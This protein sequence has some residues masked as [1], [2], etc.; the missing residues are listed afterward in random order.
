MIKSWIKILLLY[1]S[2]RAFLDRAISIA[3][4]QG[5][6]QAIIYLRRIYR[7]YKIPAVRFGIL[8][9]DHLMTLESLEITHGVS[10]KTLIIHFCC[11]GKTYTEKAQYYLLPSL[12]ASYQSLDLI[13]FRQ[14]ILLIHCDLYAENQL[15][16]APVINEM[17]C[18]M[19]IQFLVLPPPLLEAYQSSFN[20]PHFLFKR[21]NRMNV[22]NKYFLLGALQSHAFKIALQSKV[23]ISF[24]MPDLVV[25][26]GFF[27]KIFAEIEGKTL[28]VMTAFRTNYQAVKDRLKVFY[29]PLTRSLTIPAD[30]LTVLQIEHMHSAAK[31]RIVSERTENFSPSAQ[32]IFEKENGFTIR[33]FHYHPLLINCSNITQ[34]LRVDYKPIDC[35]MLNQIVKHDMPYS[36]QIGYCDDSSSLSIMEL[37]DDDIEPDYRTHKQKL[38]LD[39]IVQVIKQMMMN[40]PDVYDTPLGRYFSSIRY[41]VSSHKMDKKKRSIDD[42]YFFEQLGNVSKVSRGAKKVRN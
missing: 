25:S 7:F 26:D 42:E 24:M 15:S 10:E 35:L 34:A 17:R 11:W 32:L 29:D 40:A 37:S 33:A 20:V 4:C 22:N 28:V 31:R 14:I 6:N 27:K 38:A 3:E 9:Y 36:Q 19:D 2:G 16:N 23:Y 41:H 1:V 30:R 21:M 13:P 39:E 8:L 18:M 5:I 12:K